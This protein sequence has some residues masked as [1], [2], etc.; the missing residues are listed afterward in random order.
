V[1]PAFRESSHCIG[2]RALSRG[3]RAQLREHP[4]RDPHPRRS[5]PR[6]VARLDVAQIVERAM[7]ALVM[8]DSSP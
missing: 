3:S 5:P 1:K 6:E 2:V 8:A 7:R 4:P